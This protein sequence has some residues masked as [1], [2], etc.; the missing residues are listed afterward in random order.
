MRTLVLYLLLIS[1]SLL[2]F[3]PLIWMFTTAIKPTEQMFKI[4]P[5]WIPNPPKWSIFY[6]TWTR[7]NFNIYFIN[8]VKITF[9]SIIGRMLSCALV[10]YSFARLRWPG[11]EF[12]F[13]LTLSTMMLPFQVLMIPQFLIFKSWGWI[14]THLPLWVP[15]FA[16]NAFFIFLM[17][18]YI[19]TLPRDLD[20][21]AKIDGC[22]SLGILWRILLPLSRPALATVAIFTFMRE[23]NS[24]LEPLIFLNK[25]KMFTMAL[26]LAMFRDQFDVDW[27]AIMAMS[28]LMILPCLTVFFIAQKYFI[29]GIS[30]TGLKG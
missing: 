6:D 2:F 22:S 8:T 26:G 20:D 13:V 7:A 3:F 5:I 14:N 4:P 19:M 30:T 23:W 25:S 24:F 16:G 28:F 10:A 21:A 1:I 18:Q 12:F 11:R 17:R 27:N 15:S 29:Q 9:L